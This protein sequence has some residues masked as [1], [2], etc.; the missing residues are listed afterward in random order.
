LVT[1]PSDTRLED[2]ALI[3]RILFISLLALP[4]IAQQSAPAQPPAA[5]QSP[6]AAAEPDSKKAVAVINGETIT[7]EKLN[8]MY[9]NLNTQMRQNYDSNGGKGALLENYI[10]KRLVVQAAIKSGFN[11]QPDIVEALDAARESALFDR[12]VR[13]VVAA[14]IITDSEIKAYYNEHP[15]DFATP[16]KVHVRHIVTAV[17]SSGSAPKSREAARDAITKIAVE[18]HGAEMASARGTTDPETLARLR[19]SHFQ[20]AARKYSEDGAAASGGDLGWI[21]KG[22]TDPDFE[23]AAWNMR[24]G[25]LSGI[26]E[27]KFGFHLIY[28]EDRQPAGTEPFEAVKTSLREYL[29]TQ[30]ASDVVNAVT[31]LTNELRD[32]GHVS[33][34][35]GNIK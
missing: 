35:P 26:V 9:N 17:T 11:K 20:D 29:L 32:S 8:R 16:E 5:A 34:F 2:F 25:M 12:Y 4:A 14:P 15:G 18:L 24:A 19:L 23:V 6:S 21:T 3:K 28:V 7:V 27:S 10:R 30:K 22:Q 1:A 33:V 31:K 13:D